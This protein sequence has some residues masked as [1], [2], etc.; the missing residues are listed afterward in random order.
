MNDQTRRK[1]GMAKSSIT[2]KQRSKLVKIANE[3]RLS[4]L[5]L[6]DKAEATKQ[7]QKD[8]AIL[9]AL[10]PEELSTILDMTVDQQHNGL[11][12]SYD[13][14]AA[15]YLRFQAFCVVARGILADGKP[16]GGETTWIAYVDRYLKKPDEKLE[17]CQRRIRRLLAGSNPA[18]DK[19]TSEAAKKRAE[20]KRQREAAALLTEEA[21]KRIT[22]PDE[23]DP[24]QQGLR[25]GRAQTAATIQAPLAEQPA[26]Q[27]L[28]DK[29]EALNQASANETET[30]IF[31]VNRRR[32]N[33]KYCSNASRSN[34]DSGR[35]NIFDAFHFADPIR[36]DGCDL[37]K[38][39]ATFNFE[40]VTPIPDPEPSPVTVGER[41]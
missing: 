36:L 38:V 23:S 19:Y 16:F 5:A 28:E 35:T 24:Y 13:E 41:Q 18:S 14:T 11:L 26:A 22:F 12:E 2:A 34:I 15:S 30:Q 21:K 37:V 31:Y 9:N 10:P 32:D 1:H 17:T 4:A 27:P 3:D 6:V 25:D 7:Q 33:G 40:T 20:A 39:T 29:I 8:T